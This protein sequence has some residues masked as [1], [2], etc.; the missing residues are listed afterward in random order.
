MDTLKP[1][2]RMNMKELL[3]RAKRLQYQPNEMSDREIGASEVLDIVIEL[4]SKLQE[5]E[6]G[7]A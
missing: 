1:I 7:T 4:I 3:D 5:N 2:R 6:H